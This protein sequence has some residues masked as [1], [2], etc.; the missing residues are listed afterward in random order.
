MTVPFGSVT[1]Y[2]RPCRSYSSVVVE[3][4]SLAPFYTLESLATSRDPVYVIVVIEPSVPSMVPGRPKA[5]N[6]L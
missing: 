6:P 5:S 3:L 2:R 1:L 4:I